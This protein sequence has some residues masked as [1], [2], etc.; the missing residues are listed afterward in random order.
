MNNIRKIIT[1]RLENASLDY[2]YWLSGVSISN[3]HY[4]RTQTSK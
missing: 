2:R 3:F 1:E 4:P